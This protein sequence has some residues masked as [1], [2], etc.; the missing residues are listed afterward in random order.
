M[1][2][3]LPPKPHDYDAPILIDVR[4]DNG[5]HYYFFI[6]EETAKEQNITNAGDAMELIHKLFKYESNT[7]TQSV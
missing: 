6:G 4:D 1:K 7:A 2:N 5:G 3:E